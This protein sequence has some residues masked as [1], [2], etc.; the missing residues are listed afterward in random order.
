MPIAKDKDQQ[1]PRRSREALAVQVDGRPPRLVPPASLS[2]DE[3][4][5]FLDIVDT[6]PPEHFRPSDL[7][8]L[9]RYVENAALS[10]QA[11]A[12]LRGNAVLDDGKANS[13]LAISEKTIRALVSLSMRLR[14]SPQARLDAKAATRER[15]HIG[16]RPWDYDH[17][18][19]GK[20]LGDDA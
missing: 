9:C 16:P 13:W 6:L 20:Q 18:S 15:Q 11:A 12:E 5:L 1:M 14:L 19:N 3:R 17:P 10:P 4:K 2:K 7:I 8:L